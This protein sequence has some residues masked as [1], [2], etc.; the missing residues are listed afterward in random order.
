MKRIRDRDERLFLLL[1]SVGFVAGIIYENLNYHHYSDSIAL[2]DDYFLRTFSASHISTREYL[3]CVLRERLPPFLFFCFL[4]N[5]S[6]FRIMAGGF[7]G[8]VGFLSGVLAA[9]AV[10]RQGFR[11]V[12][13]FFVLCFP[14]FIF[15]GLAY[16]MLFRYFYYHA[17]VSMTTRT[18]LMTAI[19]FM[20]GVISELYI[21]PFLLRVIS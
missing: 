13:L 19:M 9:T 17:N 2:L 12:L 1:I 11:G 21:L 16:A 10:I 7:T 4:G 20:L 5:T 14:H 8:V 3:G 18:R 6:W 15:Y